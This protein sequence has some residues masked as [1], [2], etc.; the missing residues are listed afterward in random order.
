[1]MKKT[2]GTFSVFKSLLTDT[3]ELCAFYIAMTL[4]F[5][6]LQTSLHYAS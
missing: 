1:M 6:S 5:G 4:P 3:S 2:Q